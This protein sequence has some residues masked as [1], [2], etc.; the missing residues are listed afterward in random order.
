MNSK[1]LDSRNGRN[2]AGDQEDQLKATVRHAQESVAIQ[3][4]LTPVCLPSA[5]AV[6][7]SAL[8]T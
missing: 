8:C 5:S 4:C 7:L 3:V 1:L 6:A 2:E